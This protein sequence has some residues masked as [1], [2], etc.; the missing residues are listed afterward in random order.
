MDV[1]ACIHKCDNEDRHLAVEEHILHPTVNIKGVDSHAAGL[2][3]SLEGNKF[4]LCCSATVFVLKQ[5][6]KRH[7]YEFNT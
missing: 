6:Q 1:T 4:P 7:V 2:I 5:Y 3:S